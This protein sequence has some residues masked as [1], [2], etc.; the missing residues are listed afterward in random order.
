MF[1]AK[2][3]SSLASTWRGI[4]VPR[5]APYAKLTVLNIQ[6]LANSIKKVVARRTSFRA[7]KFAPA[8]CLEIETSSLAQADGNWALSCVCFSLAQL[9]KAACVFGDK[10]RLYWRRLSIGTRSDGALEIGPPHCS[11]NWPQC[12]ELSSLP[13]G[14]A[15]RKTSAR[16]GLN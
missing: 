2:N 15:A 5:I 1:L 3:L 13:W 14:G 9:S 4:F 7:N 10:G 6:A 11:A 16:K 8:F 12:V